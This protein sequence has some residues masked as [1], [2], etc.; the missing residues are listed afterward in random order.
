M[1][2]RRLLSIISVLALS[3]CATATMESVS[4]GAADASYEAYRETIE[5]LDQLK[6]YHVFTQSYDHAY[7]EDYEY[8]EESQTDVSVGEESDQAQETTNI[9]F[10]YEDGTKEDVTCNATELEDSGQ[11]EGCQMVHTFADGSVVHSDGYEMDA[12][13]RM[14]QQYFLL[15]ENLEDATY[16]KDGDKW[17]I[18]GSSDAGNTYVATLTVDAD[19]LPQTFTYAYEDLGISMTRTISDVRYG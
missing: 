2:G 12:E 11:S 7:A 19:G 5:Q 9:Y 15:M 17:T 13:K 1:N 18:T 6:S 3:G 14:S 16:T 8:L 4:E 10:V